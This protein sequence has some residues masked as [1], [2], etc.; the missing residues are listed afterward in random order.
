[1][2]SAIMPKVRYDNAANNL[3]VHFASYSNVKPNI[4][5]NDFI[6]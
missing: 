6:K 3:V 1:M 5:T 4:I 2:S